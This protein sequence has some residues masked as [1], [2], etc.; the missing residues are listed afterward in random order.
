MSRQPVP[1]NQDPASSASPLKNNGGPPYDLHRMVAGLT[2]SHEIGP[3][4][5]SQT[6]AHPAVP[7]TKVTIRSNSEN[8]FEPH[9]ETRSPI[10]AHKAI[11]AKKA[12]R[13]NERIGPAPL[14]TG[15]RGNFFAGVQEN[16]QPRVITK[17]WR[18]R[19]ADAS[20]ASPSLSR[21]SPCGRKRDDP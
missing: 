2:H 12:T 3:V 4:S 13:H 21:P 11:R 16:P 20:L 7:G 5:V 6:L 15:R 14:L 18:G 19:R 10:R 17:R 9:S 8:A 1:V